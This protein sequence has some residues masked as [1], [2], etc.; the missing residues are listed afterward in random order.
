[1]RRKAFTLFEL[2]I[3]LVL[4]GLV[5]GVVLTVQQSPAN[6]ECP[7][8]MRTKLQAV[9]SAMDRFAEK[10]DRLPRP[11]TRTVAVDDPSFG[12]EVASNT[13]PE[14]D[15]VNGVSF[16]A[17][18]FQ[19]LG[20]SKEY[21]GD[22]YGNKL[23]YAVTTALTSTNSTGGFT[24]AAVLGNIT[25]NSAT[26]STVNTKIAYAVISHGPDGLGAVAL[27]HSGT[28][29]DWCP[30]ATG[31]KS[32]NCNLA[33][34]NPV[35][36][37][38][39]R[40]NDGKNADAN[41]YFD[42]ILIAEGKPH[43]G[44]AASPS[45]NLYAWGNNG[46]GQL[47]ENSDVEH[48]IPKPILA[49]YT[50]TSVSV[51]LSH[52][53][54]LSMNKAYCWGD[55]TYGQLGTNNYT[56]TSTPTAVNTTET[57]TSISSGAYHTCGL[58]INKKIFCWGDNS[59]GE[60]GN[61]SFNSNSN[62]PTPLNSSLDFLSLSTGGDWHSCALATDGSAYCWGWNERGELGKMSAPYTFNGYPFNNTPVP[63]NGGIKFTNLVLSFNSSCGLTNS[64]D[65][66]CW[67]DNI[68]GQL[69]NNA[70]DATIHYD[71][72]HVTPVV[73]F[74]AIF[75][76]KDSNICTT[77]TDGNNYCWGNN[78]SGQLA[79][80]PA[81]HSLVKPTLLNTSIKFSSLAPGWGFTCGIS[82]GTVYCWG[83]N[84]YGVFGNNAKSYGN[85]ATPSPTN[86]MPSA[87]KQISVGSNH[88]TAII[89]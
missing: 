76:S 84:Y 58:T 28:S 33:A 86:A 87:A 71:P 1:M 77:G 32:M 17:L 2:S 56:P 47:G 49:T 54:A 57:F 59:Y 52:T 31:L 55:N 75:G 30:T 61:A 88:A 16:G 14:I 70:N 50:F 82:S 72:V 8:L 43:A 3:A 51:G 81:I 39:A 15:S 25:L 36:L 21:A 44:T 64:G 65:I 67:G 89:Q 4:I 11:A 79:Q 62:I 6:K 69:G 46:S 9:K 26:S 78:T 20:L 38:D 45:T 35:T 60:L 41:T 27:N 29:H 37:A 18:P 19:A 7:A 74:N 66:Y 73:K 83:N 22:C 24:D 12:R 53:C 63:V 5:A 23:S 85:N 34:N 68:Q 13:A 48:L 40:F 10:N 80:D 42:D